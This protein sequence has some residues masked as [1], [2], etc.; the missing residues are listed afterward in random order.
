MWNVYLPKAVN[1][2]SEECLHIFNIADRYTCTYCMCK[3]PVFEI[4]EVKCW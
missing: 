3:F 4:F 1:A 2:K